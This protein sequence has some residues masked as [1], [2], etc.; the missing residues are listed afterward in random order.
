M[1]R[2]NPTLA[3]A[4]LLPFLAQA[5]GAASLPA[6]MVTPPG[7]F[8]PPAARRPLPAKA[9]AAKSAPEETWLD[10]ARVVAAYLFDLAAARPAPARPAPPGPRPTD[11]AAEVPEAAPE[12]P[13]PVVD[14]PA[15]DRMLIAMAPG[16]RVE[17]VI[18]RGEED[19]SAP[20]S[21]RLAAAPMPTLPAFRERAFAQSGLSAQVTYESPHG[22]V[23]G[24]SDG[25]VAMFADGTKR[26]IAGTLPP[27]LRREFPIYY[28]GESIEVALTLVNRTGHP[29]RGLRVT[30]VQETFR[31]VGGE[32]MR[33]S[34]P[35]ELTVPGVLPA[36]GSAVV[37]WQV[38]LEGPSHA[39]V[40][41][42]QTHV[43][44]DAGPANGAAPLLDAPQAGVIDPP[45][46]GVL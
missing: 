3:V 31:P 26:F 8:L 36:G 38:V 20:P 1:A 9:A 44:V 46:P 13:A 7:A 34:P 39:A 35:A 18:G 45:G 33:L 15:H 14:A 32:G 27:A 22:I 37:R 12:A 23:H 6:I 5:T 10:S 2:R 11:A 40:N 16:E 30:A 17:G 42:E 28:H 4:A 29:L 41:L 43:T 19:L 21:A 25:Y 24:F